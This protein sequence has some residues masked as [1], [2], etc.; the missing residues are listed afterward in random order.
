MRN[1][2]KILALVLALMMVLSVMVTASASFEDAESINY[3]EAVTVLAQAGILTGYEAADGTYTFKPEGTLTRAE[4]AT[5]IARVVLAD[6]VSDIVKCETVFDDV[7]DAHW[8][9]G[10]V[11]FCYAEGYVNGMSATEYAPEGKLTVEQFAKM[12]LGVL[13]IPGTYTGDKWYVDVRNNA[14]NEG[15]MAGMTYTWTAEAT[16]EQAAQMAFNAMTWTPDGAVVTGN[17]I[18]VPAVGMTDE[19]KLALID[20]ASDEAFPSRADALV[21]MNALGLT[22]VTDYTIEAEPG[23]TG[24]LMAEFSD[25]VYPAYGEVDAYGRPLT[26]VWYAVG[27]VRDTIIY[28]E[29]VDPIKTY[30][31]AVDYKTIAKDLKGYK[32]AGEKVEDAEAV[33]SGVV[34]Y[35][36]YNNKNGLTVYD[37]TGNS[38]APAVRLANLTKNGREVEIY[39]DDQKNIEGIVVVD[40]TVDEVVISTDAYGNVTYAL[41]AGSYTD[42]SDL[43]IAAYKAA[44]DV[45]LSDTVAVYGEVADQDHVTYIVVDGVAQI[46]A[47][48]TV[49]GIL[50][51]KTANGQFLTIGGEKIAVGAASGAQLFADYD[52]K[53]EAQAFVLDQ[54]GYV[55]AEYTDAISGPVYSNNFAYVLDIQAQGFVAASGGDLIASDSG[56]KDPI[57]KAIV[58]LAD[59]TYGVIDLAVT[60]TPVGDGTYT[61]S[62]TKP[63]ADG[64]VVTGDLNSASDNVALGGGIG[65]WFGYTVTEDGTYKLERVAGYAGIASDVSNFDD[66]NLVGS[67]IDGKYITST[68]KVTALKLNTTTGKVTVTDLVAADEF[69]ATGVTAANVVY[70]YNNTN[71]TVTSI[72]VYD[73]LPV[74]TPAPDYVL[75][76]AAGDQVGTSAYE[77]DVYMNGEVVTIVVNDGTLVAGDLLTVSAI[78]SY[79][80]YTL[81]S[82]G[83]LTDG[84]KV[85]VAD[86]TFYIAEGTQYVYDRYVEIYNVTTG[87][88]GAADTIEVNDYVVSFDFNSDSDVDLIFIVDKSEV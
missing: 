62:Y 86:A 60:A 41:T 87:A 4:A 14:K 6:D 13:E 63:V 33:V 78:D 7:T 52:I 44:Y 67:T 74:V 66:A 26:N 69:D 68:T 22:L 82:V 16:R 71:G 55:V 59:G 32:L 1:L 28:S 75:V 36:H 56:A 12:L 35:N 8:A 81:S 54:Y 58:V 27:E 43:F 10:Y 31:G 5:I 64:T 61:Y 42:Y 17:Y 34:G 77:Y 20:I 37:L 2:K 11:D 40:Y 38:L 49:E 53:T 84:I 29:T 47:T 24:G 18:V 76:K 25:L 51:R 83:A 46:Y 57:A 73:F 50:S 30:T 48:E 80:V 15:L 88:T 79:G 9:S 85:T 21:Y 39:A 72:V 70:T 45:T 65:A 23:A 19:G 3:A